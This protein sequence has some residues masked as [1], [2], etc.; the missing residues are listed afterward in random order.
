MM[1]KII[2]LLAVFFPLVCFAQLS[3]IVPE[4]INVNW[5][6]TTHLIFKSNIKYF[7]AV[8]NYL[9][10]KKE[11]NIL[12]LKANIK[13]FENVTSLSVATADGSYHNYDVYYAD[14]LE[15]S[16][17][18]VNST[19]LEPYTIN[20]NMAGDVH[21][22]FPDAINFVEYGSNKIEV[23]SAGNL[24][25]LL[26]IETVEP[27]DFQTNLTV[28]TI[29][30]EYFCFNINY[31]E[32]EKR[33]SYSLSGKEEVQLNKAELTDEIRTQIEERV[34]RKGRKIYT[35]GIR[36]NKVEFAVHNIFIEDNKLI[37]QFSVDNK[38]NIPYDIDYMK[39]YIIDKKTKQTAYQE[40]PVLPLFIN[41]YEPL[42]KGKSKLN[43]IVCFEKFTIPDDKYFLIDI[44]EKEGGRH[45]KYRLQDADIIN[46]VRL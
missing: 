16:T 18:M 32:N 15:N 19:S 7:S 37:F 22:L 4:R 46:V 25:N 45:I 9:I 27:F 40:T 13:E 26:R 35:L 21:L 10:A 36:Q 1:K 41:K 30:G 2:S 43:L 33:Y 20:V 31:N 39:F 29:R 42:I 28:R 12:S 17:Y 38:S 3:E 44:N 24:E 23:S 14:T 34:K 5:Y 6:K 11:S 8:D